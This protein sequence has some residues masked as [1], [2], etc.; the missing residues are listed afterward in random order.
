MLKYIPSGADET[1]P[2]RSEYFSWINNTNEGATEAMTLANLNFFAF[3]RETF[4]MQ[5]DIYAFDAGAIDGKGFYGRTDSPRFRKQFP[6]GL[7]LLAG[8][9]AETGTRLGVWGGPDGFGTTDEEAQSRID[10]MVEL[11]Q[12]FHFALFKFDSVCGTLRPKKEK[13][14]IRM[15]QEC[16]R[17][18]PDLI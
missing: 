12:K 14:F 1:T 17:Y 10:Q 7:A 8:I 11:C 2:S 13:Y 3:L 5:L 9:A 16:R 15:M 18:S 6:H 4:S